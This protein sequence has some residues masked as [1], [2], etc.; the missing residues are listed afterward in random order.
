MIETEQAVMALVKGVV[1]LS[2][3][4]RALAASGSPDLVQLAALKAKT[5]EISASIAQLQLA[6]P[7]ECSVGE[8]PEPLATSASSRPTEVVSSLDDLFDGL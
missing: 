7:E 6:E 1:A 4:T 5:A 3:A 8:M 2:E